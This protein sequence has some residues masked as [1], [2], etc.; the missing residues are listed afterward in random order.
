M[1]STKGKA[2]PAEARLGSLDCLH[3]LQDWLQKP[4]EICGC[5]KMQRS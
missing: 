2:F 3:C 5:E 1:N 4:P